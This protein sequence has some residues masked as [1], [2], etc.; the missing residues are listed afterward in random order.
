MTRALLEGVAFGLKDSF[1]LIRNAGLA[2]VTQIRVT[3][4]GTKGYLWRQVLADVLESELVGVNTTEGSAFGAALLAGVGIGF[5]S[6]V[7]TACRDTI[8]ITGI[9]SPN[10]SN[11]PVYRTSYEIYQGLY[12]SLK[13]TFKKINDGVKGE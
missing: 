6:D 9:T 11:Y 13:N 4:G 3:G 12:P 5:W 8:H 1:T 2:K 7:V 10:P